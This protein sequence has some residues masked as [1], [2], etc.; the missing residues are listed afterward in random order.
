MEGHQPCQHLS[1]ASEARRQPS[2]WPDRPAA[3]LSGEW[4]ARL[5]EEVVAPTGYAV[6]L[7][8]KNT[9]EDR[10]RLENVKRCP[11]SQL[12]ER[13]GNPP[14]RAFGRDRPLYRP[15]QLRPAGL[16]GDDDHALGQGLEFPV[17]CSWWA[18]RASSPSAPS[19][20][21]GDGGGAPAVLR[22]HDPY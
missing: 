8:Q 3:Q 16:R 6:M 21:G 20:A 11:S 2:S 7:E 4:T 17:W 12:P 9:V 19:G 18:W 13:A 14:W 1:G 15:G 10:T 5:Y 22:G